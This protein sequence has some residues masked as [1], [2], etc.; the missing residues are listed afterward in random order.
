[1]SRV[2]KIAR[3]PREIRE[4]LNRRMDD[5]EPGS[6]LL[7]WL[8]GLPAVREVM[9]EQFGGAAITKCNLSHWRKGGFAEW[10][11]ERDLVAKAR[12]LP[13]EADE[14]EA[15]AGGDIT[16]KL[17]TV[18]AAHYA[19]ALAGWDGESNE[20]FRA[21]LKVLR[22]LSRPI[23]ALRRGDHHLARLKFDQE[24]LE[25]A[26]EKLGD[27]AKGGHFGLEQ[28][29]GL[30]LEKFGSEPAEE[31]AIALAPD[32]EGHKLDGG[33]DLPPSREAG[34]GP[35]RGGAY[36]VLRKSVKSRLRSRW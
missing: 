33:S 27:K 35:G 14:L 24:R 9:G 15:A 31:P 25:F 12:E 16:R 36:L 8:E 21:R 13:R 7:P 6:K 26:W 4:E 18:V 32:G 5:G 10:R 30:V 29:V 2:G 20:A 11:A 23:V 22:E 3:L 1:M 17:G 28:A 34:G 19:A